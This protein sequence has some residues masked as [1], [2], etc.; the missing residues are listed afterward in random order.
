M[1]KIKKL[2][3]QLDDF[4]PES[5]EKALR[6]LKTL[7]EKGVVKTAPGR[8]WVNLHGHTFFSFN[9]YGF[10]PSRFLWEAFSLGLEMAGIVDFDVL[11]GLEETLGAAQILGMKAEVGI[12]TRVFIKEYRD[13]VINS[14]GEPGI[15]YLMGTGFFRQ[16]EKG[17]RAEMTLDSLRERAKSR[18]LLVIEKVNE[19]LNPVT[20]DYE[21]DVFPLT[22][23]GNA[24]ERHILSAY[25]Q[26]ASAVFP[27]ME[28]RTAFWSEI[29][30]LPAETVAAKLEKPHDFQELL[31][32]KLMK[33]EGV[34]YV[35]P[36]PETFPSV[37]EV[38]EMISAT[39]AIPT[40]TWLDG[41]SEAEKDP[42]KLLLF[43]K[44][45][46]MSILNVVP[47]RNYNLKDPAERAVKVANLNAVMAA[48][49]RLKMPVIAGTEMNKYG[50]PLVDNFDAPEL[51]PYLEYFRKAGQLLWEHTVQ[52]N[53]F[54]GEGLRPLP[55]AG[56]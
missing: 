11:D 12:E 43:I 20:I 26:K 15:F 37:E 31:R 17:S 10:S 22:P 52:G 4:D 44:E 46:G 56:T 53:R 51:R 6:E 47:E 18:N 24:T 38:V 29:L 49:R 16:P 25:N 14:P 36:G 27:E 42:E 54:A 28:K 2:V 39:G 40:G 21:N 45:K 50:Q 13:R 19:Y 35:K 32:S 8:G 55:R 9:A 23:R 5:R 33:G 34:G 30:K 1:E 7:A 48:A 41:T 3:R